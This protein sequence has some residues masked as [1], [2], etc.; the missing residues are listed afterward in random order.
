M[1]LS[2]LPFIS[3]KKKF[4]DM[5]K[6][7]AER[8]SPTLIIISLKSQIYVATSHYISQTFLG[9][10]CQCQEINI[11]NCYYGLMGIRPISATSGVSFAATRRSQK[12]SISPTQS[13]HY[14]FPKKK[15]RP[16]KNP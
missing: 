1:T 12:G 11:T 3:R 15:H 14:F 6:D 10:T 2:P 7:S 5:L 16:A 9:P 4:A 13:C 8:Y